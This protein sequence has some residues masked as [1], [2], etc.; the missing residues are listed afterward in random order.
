MKGAFW[1][2]P[3]LA[4]GFAV[5]GTTGC[6]EH[7]MRDTVA[8]GMR[9]FNYDYATP[10]F[11]G[12]EDT[13][14][15]CAM[16]EGMGGM[17]YPMG[18]EVDPLVPM[19]SL[20]AGMCADEKS[21]EQELRYMRAM[22]RNDVE[23]AQDARTQQRR[24]LAL[25]AKRQYFGY[26]ALIRAYGKPKEGCPKFKDDNYEFSYLQGLL[27]GLQAFQN[28][29][30]T[31]GHARVPNDTVSQVMTGLKCL[32]SDKYWGLPE[33]AMT[34]MDVVMAKAGGDSAKLQE[35]YDRIEKA[36]KVGQD[37]GVRMVDALRAQMYLMQS[38]QEA[39]KRVIREHAA[40]I[41]RTAS[42]PD[43]R[44]MDLMATRTIRSLSD[45]MWTKA[46]GKRTPFGKLGTFWDEKPKLDKALDIDELL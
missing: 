42:N 13:D 10:W 24:W 37:A 4:A 32:D 34:V 8:S 40:S 3:L 33:A 12:S 41:K 45:Y 5:L 23:T 11:L 7:F 31:G 19:L 16:G 9:D 46:T 14:V 36:A 29:F 30:A 39:A 43:F 35:G 17:I 25:A 1:R 20:S 21:K 2:L 22:R 27:N 6:S 26:Q 44:L 18:P 28:D 15:M 38:D